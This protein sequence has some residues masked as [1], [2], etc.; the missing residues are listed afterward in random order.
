M[1]LFTIS[2]H[3][4]FLICRRMD[5]RRVAIVMKLTGALG[6]QRFVAKFDL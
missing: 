3:H 2:H 4:L 5:S 6:S 1:F